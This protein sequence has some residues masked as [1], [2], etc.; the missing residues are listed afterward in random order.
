MTPGMMHRALMGQLVSFSV[1]V[2]RTSLIEIYLHRN[3]EIF[4]AIFT[5]RFDL[6]AE[7]KRQAVIYLFGRLVKKILDS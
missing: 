2:T 1:R 5:G 6:N 7:G 4:D 3:G